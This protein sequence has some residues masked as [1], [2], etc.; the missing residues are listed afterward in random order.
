LTGPLPNAENFFIVVDSSL[1]NIYQVDAVSGATGQLLAFGVASNPKAVA[2]DPTGNLIYWTDYN[3]HT[4]NRYSL[5]TNRSTVIYHDPSNTGK[6][7][8]QTDVYS[9]LDNLY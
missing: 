9:S 4:I 3:L 5:L 1:W 8:R 6:D 2:Y 7:I